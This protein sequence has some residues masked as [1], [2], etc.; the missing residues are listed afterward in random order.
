MYFILCAGGCT[1]DKKS[2]YTRLILQTFVVALL[3]CREEVVKYQP[4]FKLNSFFD[5]SLLFLG[6]FF[7]NSFWK[8]GNS[9]YYP[10]ISRRLIVLELLL[11]ETSLPDSKH[12][13]NPLE[14]ANPLSDKSDKIPEEN[15]RIIK[16]TICQTGG[17]SKTT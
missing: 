4:Y 15:S 8:H 16:T 6:N 2:I 5:I 13:K 14:V 17:H 10:I 1:D 7:T 3:S 12:S 9:G 11:N